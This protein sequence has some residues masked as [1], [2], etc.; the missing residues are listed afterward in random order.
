MI[1]IIVFIISF[2]LLSASGQNQDDII[3]YT[4]SGYAEFHSSVPLDT[5]TGKSDYLT[6][7]ID[8]SEN[9]IDFYLDLETLKTG[10]NRRDRDMYRTLKVDNYPFAEF[11]GK[12]DSDFD[13]S[14]NETQSV[15]ATGEFKVHGVSRE[16]T[17]EGSL[18]K[19]SDSLLLKAEWILDLRDHDIEPPGILIYRVA[20]EIEIEIEATLEAK[21]RDEL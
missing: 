21:N 5:F 8:L 2:L 12:L 18:Q 6:G 4:D 15:K 11:T 19:I 16:V 7:M 9:E 17:I 10:N 3:Y 20:D 1:P 13:E 14:T